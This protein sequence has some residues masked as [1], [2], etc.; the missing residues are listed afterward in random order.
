MPNAALALLD[1]STEPACCALQETRPGECVSVVSHPNKVL[2]GLWRA[3]REPAFRRDLVWRKLPRP[4]PTF[5]IS[6]DTTEDRYPQIFRFVRGELAGRRD[7][8]LLS[9]GCSTGEEVFTLRQY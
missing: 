9:F 7:L 3:A 8:R 1:A 2:R 6:G 5:Q 4:G